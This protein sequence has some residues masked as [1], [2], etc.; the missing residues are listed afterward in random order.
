MH[1]RDR[2]GGGAERERGR[3]EPDGTAP[4]SPMWSFAPQ[5]KCGDT[6]MR[7]CLRVQARRRRGSSV[8]ALT[9]CQTA[10]MTMTRAAARAAAAAIDGVSDSSDDEGE[11]GGSGSE[12]D[13]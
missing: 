3:G 2:R 13:L 7:R 5:L 12:T 10:A 8:R 6:P 4:R 1:E 9:A 11:G